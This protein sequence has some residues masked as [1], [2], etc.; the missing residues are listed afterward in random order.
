MSD[1]ASGSTASVGTALACACRL[2]AA[3][4]GIQLGLNAAAHAIHYVRHERTQGQLTTL[5]EGRRMIGMSSG[6]E[7]RIGAG[8]LG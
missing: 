5:R 7:E 4:Q 2:Q 8:V 3:K 6:I 1:V